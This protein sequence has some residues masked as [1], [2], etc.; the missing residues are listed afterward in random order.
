MLRKRSEIDSSPT[1]KVLR[2]VNNVRPDAD[3]FV[4][5]FYIHVWILGCSTVHEVGADRCVLCGV[6]CV[7]RGQFKLYCLNHARPGD[8]VYVNFC[9]GRE[10]NARSHLRPLRGGQD[11]MRVA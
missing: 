4:V 6:M 1:G 9:R 10:M 3:N 8:Q 2:G 5:V 7:V 11:L